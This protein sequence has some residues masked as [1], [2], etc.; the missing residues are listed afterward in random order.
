MLSLFQ[1]L[2]EVSFPNKPYASIIAYLMLLVVVTALFFFTPKAHKTETI[3]LYLGALGV[4]IINSIVFPETIIDLKKDILSISTSK[5]MLLLVIS[6]I[7]LWDD[8]YLKMK[9]YSIPFLSIG[10]LYLIVYT[11]GYID[12]GQT[13]YMRLAYNVL[14]PVCVIGFIGIYE[15]KILYHI[16]F[17]FLLL[18]IF[19][20]GCRGALLVGCCV[21]FLLLINRDSKVWKKGIL[22]MLVIML[23]I[24]FILNINSIGKFLYSHGFDS[25][26]IEKLDDGTMF[27]SS[28]RYALRAYTMST[29]QQEGFKPYGLYGDREIINQFFGERIYIHNIILEFIVDFGII[30]GLLLFICLIRKIYVLTKQTDIIPKLFLLL[31][32]AYSLSKL[33]LSSSFIIEDSF[34]CLLGVMIAVNRFNKRNHIPLQ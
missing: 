15:M 19:F 9:K 14:L 5:L 6:N 17:W 33:M 1:E 31:F 13:D 18:A 23:G 27:D 20:T 8:F 22:V 12:S 28:G 29:I 7:T 26:I 30:I 25:R 34:Y 2:V 32:A 10:I 24:I 4:F 21:Y 11:F 16:I 3:L